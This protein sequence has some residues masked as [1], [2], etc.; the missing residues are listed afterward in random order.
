MCA[1]GILLG[2]ASISGFP[3]Q[4]AVGALL[5]STDDIEEM[6]ASSDDGVLSEDSDGVRHPWQRKSMHFNCVSCYSNI[7]EPGGH[8]P[9]GPSCV[10]LLLSNLSRFGGRFK[11]SLGF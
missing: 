8:L 5:F 11:T 9:I 6:V 10:G 4:A 7:S 1:A 3:I 2:N